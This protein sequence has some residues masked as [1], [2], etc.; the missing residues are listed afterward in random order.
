MKLELATPHR[1]QRYSSRDRI[2][3]PQKKKKQ[4]NKQTT[5]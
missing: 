3:V 2:L 4:T 1:L 5:P